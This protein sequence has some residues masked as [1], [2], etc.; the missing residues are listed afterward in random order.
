MYGCGIAPVPAIDASKSSIQSSAASVIADGLAAAQITV[1]L[2]NGAGK[3]LPGVQISLVVG[4]NNAGLSVTQPVNVTD[5]NGVAVGSVRATLPGVITVSPQMATG[6]GLITLP[7]K[8]TITF[9]FNQSNACYVDNAPSYVVAVPIFPNSFAA[10]VGGQA[11]YSVS[12]ALPHGLMLNPSTGVIFGTPQASTASAIYVI[13]KTGPAVSASCD[14][15]ITVDNYGDGADGGL[16]V[17]GLTTFNVNAF[18]T[19][20]T[21]A[22]GATSFHVDN[23]QA[24]SAGHEIMIVQTQVQSGSPTILPYE[25]STILS[26]IAG[27]ITVTQPIIQT[28]TSGTSNS[29]SGAQVTQI[30]NVPHYAGVNVPTGSG[31]IAPPWDGSK[32]GIIAFRVQ[33]TLQVDGTVTAA[34]LGFRGGAHGDINS[35]PQAIAYG[36]PGESWNGLAAYSALHNQGGGGGGSFNYTCDTQPADGNGGGGGGYATAGNSGSGNPTSSEFGGDAGAAYGAAD[37]SAGF[38]LGSGGGGPASASCGLTT[39]P[40]SSGGG[41]A[42]IAAQ[43]ITLT[44]LGSIS[45]QGEDAVNTV[46]TPG[47]GAGGTLYLTADNMTLGNGQVQAQGGAASSYGGA[48]GAGFIR[49]DCGCN[50]V[51]GTTNPPAQFVSAPN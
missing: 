46:F 35:R 40:G 30:V 10:Q 31:I 12:P 26:S 48:G 51:S 5:A 44:S 42:F 4:G 1:V 34:G 37:L 27:T 9:A 24:F 11:V 28:Y 38:Y 8:S 14:L 43:S 50:L 22:A 16:T 36:Y 29:Y 21:I 3:P 6:A 33:T 49:L 39:Y 15:N 32:G 47:A 23:W 17:S 2:L 25:H 41:A 13:S 20:N 7:V 19:D 18:V 45:V